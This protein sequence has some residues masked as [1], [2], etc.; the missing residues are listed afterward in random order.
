[1]QIK[2]SFESNTTFSRISYRYNHDKDLYSQLMLLSKD[3]FLISV[4][5]HSVK[6]KFK[7]R[8]KKTTMKVGNDLYYD[9]MKRHGTLR[10]KTTECTS[11]QSA[12]GFDKERVER[13]YLELT[14]LMEF[15]Y[16]CPAK[17]ILC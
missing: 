3:E 1:M 14:E 11:L 15:F 9:F 16:F 12:A 5:R 10:F 8:F 6:T 4:Y 17:N 13:F 7:H 2:P